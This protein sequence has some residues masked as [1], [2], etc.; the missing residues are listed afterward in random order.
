MNQIERVSK[1]NVCDICRRPDWCLKLRNAADE[2]VAV[3]CARISD[4]AVKRCG[5]AGWLHILKERGDRGDQHIG[6][7]RTLTVPDWTPHRPDLPML[8]RRYATATSPERL[9]RLAAELGLTATSLKRLGVGWSHDYQAWSFPMCDA[10]GGTIGIRLRLQ[11]GKKISVRGG[12]EGL[13]LPADL[14]VPERLIITEGATDAV[15]FMDWGF[16]AVGRPSCSGGTRLLANLIRRLRCPEIVIVAD[17]DEPG[18][19]GAAAL[20]STLVIQTRVRLITPPS[21]FKD[22]R[23]WK[24]SGAVAADVHA[25]IA[26]AELRHLTVRMDRS[27]RQV[28]HG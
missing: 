14:G 2:V 25:A 28:Q 17:G 27:G 10:D 1:T 5:D 16:A 24:Q 6:R 21:G 7:L 13:F 19:R 3:I 23:S 20:A 22:A 18:Q 12:R 9:E 11:S 26:D 8:A 15:A 4:G